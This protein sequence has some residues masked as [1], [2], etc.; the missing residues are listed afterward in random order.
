MKF[1]LAGDKNEPMEIKEYLEEVVLTQG[2]I[3]LRLKSN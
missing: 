3:D 1:K 2:W